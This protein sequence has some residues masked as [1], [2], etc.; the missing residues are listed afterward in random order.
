MTNRRGAVQDAYNGQRDDSCP[1]WDGEEGEAF[2]HTTQ[3]DAQF[4]T[5]GGSISGIFH[6]TF[7]TPVDHKKQNHGVVVNIVFP[8]DY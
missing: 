5:Y 7:Q 6:L 1:G 4:K 3:K 8:A 2:P